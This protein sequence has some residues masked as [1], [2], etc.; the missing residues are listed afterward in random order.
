MLSLTVI[1]WTNINMAAAEAY[2]GA[3]ILVIAN[4]KPDGQYS[5]QRYSELL[6]VGL[7]QIGVVPHIWYPPVVFG[8]LVSPKSRFFKWL[9]YLDKFVLGALVLMIVLFFWKRVHICDHSNAIYRF[10]MWRKDVSVTCHDVIAIKAA[11]GFGNWKVKPTGRFF[12]WLILGGLR[13]CDSVLCVSN[14]TRREL[15]SLGEFAEEHTLVAYNPIDP[16]LI[17]ALPHDATSLWTHLHK[18]LGEDYVIHVGQDHP[19]K[20]RLGVI[21]IFC[22]LVHHP[23]FEQSNLLLVGPEPNKEEREELSRK[24]LLHR[25]VAGRL[26]AQADLATAYRGAR[27]L[28][29]PSYL[30]GF[31][32]PIAEAQALG[33]PVFTTAAPP[34]NEI[35]GDGAIYINPDQHIE[36]ALTI[37]NANLTALSAAG[38]LAAKRFSL[39][40]MAQKVMD[41]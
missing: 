26:P 15:L 27:C 33:C 22:A 12:Q 31:G 24:G 3:R 29:F 7:K 4:Y 30:E 28:L 16:N 9:A 25:V 40:S 5:M 41:A 23:G 13:R 32:W 37:A 34:M 18:K 6:N 11:Q 35:G 1:D 20:N 2:L 38:Y 19:R 17:N 36:A 14:H 39:S 8:H 21:R 10:I